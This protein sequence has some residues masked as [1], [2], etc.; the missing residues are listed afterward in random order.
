M[1]KCGIPC[2]RVITWRK[3]VLVMQFLGQNQIPAQKLK[4][5]KL[6]AADLED[7]YQQCIKVNTR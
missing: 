1:E 4:D 5:A 6:S 2:P 7:A 3:N